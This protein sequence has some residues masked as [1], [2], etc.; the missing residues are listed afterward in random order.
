ME[1]DPANAGFQRDLGLFYLKMGNLAKETGRVGEAA[2]RYAQSVAV[3]E[4]LVELNPGKT[5]FQWD[6]GM[7]YSNLG[8][9][10]RAA[11]R[12]EEAARRYAQGL[13]IRQRL[14]ELDP[15]N[16]GFQQNLGISYAR[17]GAW[18][19]PLGATSMRSNA[20]S[21]QWISAGTWFGANPI[22]RI[23]WS[24]SA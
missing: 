10:A 8:D 22:V 24:N 18:S 15:T 12:A 1:L 16:A 3:V 7:S 14:V 13:A 21:P 20:I 5:D 23:S 17:L 2:W 4:R 9:L 11:G 6:L 19:R